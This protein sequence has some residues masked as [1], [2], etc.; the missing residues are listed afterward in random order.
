MAALP[1]CNF[2]TKD[3]KMSKPNFV[4]IL[5]DDLGYGD[6]G[7]YGADDLDTPHLD[8]MAAEGIRFTHAYSNSPVCS[9]TRAS[10]LTGR[11]PDM[12]GV[13]G[14]IRTHADNS[15]GYLS[16]D[17]KLL[18]DLL[19]PA[20][21]TS[22]LVGKWHLGLTSPNKPLQ[23]GFDHV[24]G[25]L[26]DMM[27]DYYTHRRHGYNYMRLDNETIDPEGHATDLFTEWAC[28]WLRQRSSEVPFFLYLAYNAPH[29]PIQPP[30]EWLEKV[31]K[32]EPNMDPK[33]AGL[34]AL[35]EHMDHG[36]GQVL[37]TLKQSGLDDNTLVIFWSDNGGQLNIGAANGPVR[38]GKGT[39]YEGGI[40]VPAIA[41]WP[42]HI[43]A[44]TTSNR[45]VLTMDVAP[46]LCELAGTPAAPEIDGQS[47][48][49]TFEDTTQPPRQG[50]L[51]FGRREGGGIFGRGGTIEC[52]RRGDWKL[53]RSKPGGPLE[54]YNLV[55]YPLEQKDL[56]VS[57]PA[58]L[59][60]LT[61][62]LNAQLARY[63]QVP[64][65]PPRL[66]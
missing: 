5:V 19:R 54:L 46:T 6:L 17:A 9:P 42:G 13:P 63:A 47:L 36:I 39:V 11:Y 62:A 38:D 16:P 43:P 22:T 45:V 66:R 51:F 10:L 12:V 53:L 49:P 48:V 1:R 29:V 2:V 37:D 24:H 35:I 30:A 3:S 40:R 21:Y 65:K 59:K 18:P 28:T 64:W 7:C 56:A 14:V 32:R 41:R 15:W 33:R 44:G 34:A 20:G 52:V 4:V 57:E 26:G 58:K 55:T 60:E 27:D 50:D 23:R 61:D 8:R 25:F 31:R